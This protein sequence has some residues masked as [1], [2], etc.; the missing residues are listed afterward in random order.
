MD[1]YVLTSSEEEGSAC[2]QTSI[3]ITGRPFRQGWP[4][5]PTSFNSGKAENPRHHQTSNRFGG[6]CRS[7]SSVNGSPGRRAPRGLSICHHVCS[8]R[9]AIRDSLGDGLDST[10]CHCDH[11]HTSFPV[12]QY[13]I[14][15]T[16]QRP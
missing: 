12:L 9:Q 10:N 5:P 3:R 13:P 1:R 8:L 7:I 4:F 15:P 11:R 6:C 16:S 2:S 14:L